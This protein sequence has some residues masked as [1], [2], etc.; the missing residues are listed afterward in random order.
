MASILLV[1]VALGFS[2]KNAFAAL[3]ALTM[4]GVALSISLRA[5]RSLADHEPGLSRSRGEL[6]LTGVHR[7]FVSAVEAAP[8]GD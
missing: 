6:H 1:V 4:A 3:A 2:A 8:V 5:E 7:D